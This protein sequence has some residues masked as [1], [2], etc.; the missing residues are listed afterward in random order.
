[1]PRLFDIDP[2]GVL[3]GAYFWPTNVVK[4]MSATGKILGEFPVPPFRFPNAV[5]RIASGGLIADGT[6]LLFRNGDQTGD[7]EVFP[8]RHAC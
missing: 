5:G 1:M 2:M 6:H 7:N 8:G 3:Y 4:S